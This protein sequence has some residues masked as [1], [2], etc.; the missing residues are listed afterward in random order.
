VEK[1]AIS[2][3]TLFVEPRLFSA[4]GLPLTLPDD[5]NGT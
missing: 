2:R 4:F 1:D 5:G 3:L